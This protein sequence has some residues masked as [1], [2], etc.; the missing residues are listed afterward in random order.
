[1]FSAILTCTTVRKVFLVASVFGVGVFLI[2][3][4][5]Q[6][7]S[8]NSA[9]LQWAA[10][11]EPD[12]SGYRVYHGTTSNNYPSSLD[13][14]QTTTHQFTNLASNTTHYF[15]VTAYDNSG[16]ESPP[17]PQVSK[18]IGGTNSV[19]S[20]SVSGNGSISSNPAGVSCTNGTCS[21]TFPQ[22]SSV[23]LTATPNSGNTFS[24]WAGACN[25]TNNSCVVALSTSSAS[26]TATF[27][28]SSPTS[29]TLRVFVAGNGQGSVT[30]NPTGVSCTSGLCSGTF[31][32][33]SSVTLTATPNSGNTFSGW[34]GACNGT[35]NSCV[36]T[37]S[38]SSP[39]AVATFDVS[40]P[41]SSTL[42][43]AMTGNGH[44]SVTSNPA[45]VSCTNGTCSGTFPQGSSVTLTA[46]P[47]SGNT[48]SGWAGACNGTNACV[49]ALST[50]SVSVSAT[51]D[52]SQPVSSTLN[53]AMTGNGH[54]SVTS[55][56][57]GV[58]C[59]NGTCS[60]TFPQGSSVTLTAT[61]N[62]GNTFSGW[63]GA[64]NGTNACVVALSTSSASVSATF[65][66]SQPVSST[67]RVFVAGNGQGSVTS[68]PTGVSCTSGLC[69]GTFPQGSSVTLT[70]TPNSGNT[71]SGWA[72][73]CNG[74]NNSCVVTLS[75]S[76][77]EA[78][79]TFDVRPL[80]LSTLSVAMT[81]NGQGS[82]TSN[83][84]GVSC[85]SG[86]CSGTF[87]QGSSVTLTATPN[88]GNT[89]SGWGRACNGTN[90]SCVVALST[91]SAS[92]TATF[93]PNLPKPDLPLMVNFQPSSSDVPL[94]Y[95]KDDGSIFTD[96]RGYGWD[97]LVNGN[98]REAHV[99]QTLDTF[100]QTSNREPVQWNY[101][102]PNGTYYISLAM[103][104][105]RKK[106]GPHSLNV[107]GM[108]L[109]NGVKTGKGEYFTIVEYPVSV[110]D[111]T[112][113]LTLGGKEKG[114]S[115]LNFLIIKFCT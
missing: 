59:T 45:G 61:P 24:G 109:A 112:L 94:N 63:A 31:P 68:N 50:S 14:G 72:G 102:L 26:V 93:D 28:P 17:S 41:V 10:N 22:G 88:S 15:A 56:P 115:L 70:A 33:G 62:S 25:G 69:S 58:S 44:G 106:S 65:D 57:A 99:D 43:V 113:S 60:G 104:D 12:L 79:A 20:V 4:I 11:Q 66:V 29:S 108:D 16:N 97:A 67:L 78:V 3:N 81:G 71:F 13:V 8:S 90:N 21:G 73:A 54:G 39:E 83:P 110:H 5:V 18:A 19:L 51:F 111:N 7:A 40:Q 48:F 77:P 76:S 84:T 95:T 64:C 92:V 96:S 89:F 23:T 37:L 100:L 30:S 105:P 32:Q 46:T 42:N 35:N 74:T 85:T 27:D 103:G 1:M 9:T 49:V 91:S 55:N 47:N 34:A 87:P 107:E 80:I 53:V 36:V 101:N 52:V 38:T 86:A 82:V 98:E 114:A 75:T 2:P 6:S